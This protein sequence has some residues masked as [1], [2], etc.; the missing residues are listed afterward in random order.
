MQQGAVT[1]LMPLFDGGDHAEPLGKRG[2]ALLL[3]GLGKCLVHIRPLEIF[4]G[5]GSLQIGSGI[6]NPLQL[7]EPEFGVLLLVVR[8]CLEDG[9]NLLKAFLAGNRCEVCILVS[10]LR[11]S[12]K[13]RLQVGFCLGSCVLAHK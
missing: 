1:L 9:C 8:S 3:G 12:G 10:C 5:G 11:L 4:P 2:E 7:L 6:A 13:C